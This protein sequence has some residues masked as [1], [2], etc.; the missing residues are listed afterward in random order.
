MAALRRR[1]L[2]LH[3]GLLVLLPRA[4]LHLIKLHH[5]LELRLAVLLLRR[6]RPRCLLVVPRSI[7]VFGA[8]AA[9]ASLGAGGARAG[10]GGE[11]REAA[12]GLAKGTRGAKHGGGLRTQ[13]CTAFVPAHSPKHLLAAF[14][15]VT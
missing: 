14:F 5:G 1:I 6:R 7:I 2:Q 9:A 10:D 11:A 15:G 3:C 13:R 12:R 4:G 8:A